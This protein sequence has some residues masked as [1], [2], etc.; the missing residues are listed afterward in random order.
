MVVHPTLATNLLGFH[1][2]DFWEDK[3]FLYELLQIHESY[4]S[5]NTIYISQL[6]NVFEFFK[7]NIELIFS[8]FQLE[9]WRGKSMSW[10]AR[11]KKAIPNPGPSN[12]GVEAEQSGATWKWSKKGHGERWIDAEER[13]EILHGFYSGR[14]DIRLI[15]TWIN[16]YYI[17]NITRSVLEVDLNHCV[18][19][20]LRERKKMHCK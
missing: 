15:L 20:D 18:V 12:A 17:F 10:R 16:T 13:A 11:K 7:M 3:D 8:L 9:K 5:H 14:L 1:H 6:Q 4:D 2:K 19:T